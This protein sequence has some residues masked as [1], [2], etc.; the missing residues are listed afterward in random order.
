MHYEPMT[1]APTLSAAARID[2][3]VRAALARAT[4]SLSIASA[5][6]A[7]TDW[8]IHLLA[9]P[10]KRMDL[11]RLALGQA[12][13]LS[14][15]ALECASAGPHNAHERVLPAQNDR[16]FAA[17]EWHQWPFSLYHQSFLLTQQW[18]D[19]ATHDVWGVARH[20]ENQVAFAARQWLDMLSPVNSLAT[21]PVVAEAHPR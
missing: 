7:V 15:Y 18:W 6:L 13:Q 3:A 1:S 4:S 11:M 5:L 10:G 2:P 20:H 19:A 8:A 21:N 14:R 17:Q 12:E 16:R 9:S